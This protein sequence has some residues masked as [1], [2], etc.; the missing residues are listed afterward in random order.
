MAK[1]NCLSPLTVATKSKIIACQVCTMGYYMNIYCDVN[2]PDDRKLKEQ[3]TVNLKSPILHRMLQLQARYTRYIITPVINVIMIFLSCVRISK[4]KY[5][6]VSKELNEEFISYRLQSTDTRD[7][8][9]RLCLRGY[10]QLN[11]LY[12][13]IVSKLFTIYIHY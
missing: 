13:V 11:A 1:P 5:T 6:P 10:W 2:W 3:T 9:T 12:I 7:V 8:K 4:W